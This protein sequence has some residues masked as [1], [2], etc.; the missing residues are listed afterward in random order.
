MQSSTEIITEANKTAGE[1]FEY[2]SVGYIDNLLFSFRTLLTCSD[3]FV[4]IHW[5]LKNVL[6]SSHLCHQYS[7]SN[8]VMNIYVFILKRKSHLRLVFS[9]SYTDIKLC[10]V[11]EC[12]EIFFHLKIITSLAIHDQNK[13]GIWVWRKGLSILWLCKKWQEQGCNILVFHI[14]ICDLDTEASYSFAKDVNIL[15]LT[16]HLANRAFIPN[17][18]C[19]RLTYKCPMWVGFVPQ[20]PDSLQNHR[21]P[22]L[23]FFPGLGRKCIPDWPDAVNSTH[24]VF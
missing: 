11:D 6:S 22:F 20:C 7:A 15:L 17:M 23:L 18:L 8:V 2:W 3:T 21:N 14:N 10:F 1:E 5:F 13:A 12:F 24:V 16:S 4:C 9:F 19:A